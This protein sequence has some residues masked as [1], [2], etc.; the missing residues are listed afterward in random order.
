[1]LTFVGVTVIEGTLIVLLVKLLQRVAQLRDRAARGVDLAQE[2]E[3]DHAVGLHHQGA[4]QFRIGKRLDADL[5]AHVQLVLR[6]G[7]VAGDAI[8]HVQLIVDAEAVLGH[9]F[10]PRSGPR[11]LPGRRPARR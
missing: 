8:E 2:A 6:A 1:M 9:V 10:G 11:I 4:I 3:R 5:V 7:L